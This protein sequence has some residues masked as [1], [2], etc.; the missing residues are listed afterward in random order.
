MS[1]FPK[2]FFP[3]FWLQVLYQAYALQK[4]IFSL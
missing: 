4:L 1:E 3:V 2:F